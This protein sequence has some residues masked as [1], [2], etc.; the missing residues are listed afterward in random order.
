M[1]EAGG[2]ST[3]R[4]WVA[5]Q[6]VFQIPVLR[7][8]Q[9]NLRTRFNSFSVYFPLFPSI[10]RLYDSEREAELVDIRVDGCDGRVAFVGH[11]RLQPFVC[12]AMQLEQSGSNI[13]RG[14]GA[15]LLAVGDAVLVGETAA[16]WSS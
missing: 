2:V 15:V 4:V 6:D 9:T 10:S 8:S 7:R 12:G 1:P 16:T 14:A 5:L 11:A 13:P 3:G